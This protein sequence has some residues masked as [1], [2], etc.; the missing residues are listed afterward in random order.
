VEDDI[1]A[2]VRQ[3][4]DEWEAQGIRFLGHDGPRRFAVTRSEAEAALDDFLD[5]RLSLFGPYED[6]VLWRDPFMAHSLLSVPLNLG[7][8]H[9][10]EVVAQAEERWRADQATLTSVEG[11]IRQI[12]GWREYVWHLY[13]HL[14]ESYELRNE[15]DS[16]VEPPTW[17]LEASVLEN[18]IECVERDGI[19]PFLAVIY[20]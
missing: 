4:L 20:R 17:F 16:T 12:I 11:L 10:A 5:N 18:N 13:W 9:P 14:G 6:A 7:L 1:D 19:F 8:L 2:Q 3:Q 15:L